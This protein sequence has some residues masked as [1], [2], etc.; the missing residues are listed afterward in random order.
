MELKL[1]NRLAMIG[2]AFIGIGKMLYSPTTN[3]YEIQE[4]VIMD[5]SDICE[6]E[7]QVEEHKRRNELELYYKGYKIII[8][9]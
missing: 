1:V 2:I 3:P 5:M 8:K 7:K 9:N 6:L 4:Q